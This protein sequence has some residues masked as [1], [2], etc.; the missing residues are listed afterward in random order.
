MSA[1]PSYSTKSR[2]MGP[3]GFRLLNLDGTSSA[4]NGTVPHR[5]TFYE[6]F[7]FTTKGGSHEIDFTNFPIRAGSV[8]IVT[9]GQIHR[10]IQSDTQG[11]VLCFSEEF[12][13][14][15]RPASLLDR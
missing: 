9:P 5:H 6:L 2:D 15:D 7:F 10:L 1:I 3:F 13:T 4:Y 12:A 8:H 11:L 14:L